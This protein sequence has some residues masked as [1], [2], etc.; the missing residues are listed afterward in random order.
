MLETA[1]ISMN[2][3]QSLATI[4]LLALGAVLVAVAYPHLEARFTRVLPE[5]NNAV[6]APT[7][8]RVRAA[9]HET[10]ARQPQPAEPALYD[11]ALH[12]I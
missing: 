1:L 10:P 7:T 5:A 6:D 12:G 11:H 8:G 3:L 2:P 4:A 9:R